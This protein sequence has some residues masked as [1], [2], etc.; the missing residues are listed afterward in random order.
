MYVHIRTFSC[1]HIYIYM[2]IAA[3]IDKEI[4]IHAD[5]DLDVEVDIDVNIGIDMDMS[6]PFHVALPLAAELP[7]RLARYFLAR[8]TALPVAALALVSRCKSNAC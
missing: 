3:D 7:C 6:V 2:C 4:D 8:M 1:I 5:A